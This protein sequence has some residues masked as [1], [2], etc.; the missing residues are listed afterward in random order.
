MKGLR[1]PFS[2]RKFEQVLAFP[3]LVQLQNSPTVREGYRKL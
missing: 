2:S 1:S 3:C